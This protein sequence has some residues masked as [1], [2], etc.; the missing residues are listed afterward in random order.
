MKFLVSHYTLFIFAALCVISCNS[1]PSETTQISTEQLNET[2]D[3]GFNQG[4]DSLSLLV[5]QADRSDV[6][7]DP[8]Q[9]DQV[10][11][12]EKS[13]SVK[14]NRNDKDVTENQADSQNISNDDFARAL[15]KSTDLQRRKE[16]PADVPWGNFLDSLKSNTQVFTIDPKKDTVITCKKG[17]R[18]FLPANLLM[19]SDKTGVLNPVQVE[20][21]ECTTLSEFIGEKL[22]TN[23]NDG[24]LETAGMIHIRFLEKGRE[25][26]VRDSAKYAVYFPKKDG[27]SEMNLYYGNVDSNGF[28][29]WELDTLF[30]NRT[31]VK[32]DPSLTTTA[33]GS[34]RNLSP[35]KPYYMFCKLIMTIDGEKMEDTPQ[36]IPNRSYR[37]NNLYQSFEKTLA[38]NRKMRKDFCECKLSS[39]ILVTFDGDGNPYGARFSEHSRHE[40]DSLF[41]DLIRNYPR[42]EVKSDLPG[43]GG[44]ASKVRITYFDKGETNE[45]N[46][47]FNKKYEAF[48]D[49]ALEMV[50]RAELDNYI[51]VANGGGWLNCDLFRRFSGKK[52]NILAKTLVPAATS[53]WLVFRRLYVVIPAQLKANQLWFTQMPLNEPV[54]LIAVNYEN[55]APEMA[56]MELVTK[57]KELF[58]SGFQKFSIEQLRTALD[59]N[60]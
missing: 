58:I 22:T 50:D 25:L 48:Y 28:K 10:N 59:N 43:T 30:D 56:S 8:T 40:Y 1:E 45:Q 3:S 14:T 16:K 23:S 57:E 47:E 11:N 34:N 33:F 27:I 6:F 52:I 13:N 37:T 5:D 36:G 15:L 44:V 24:L 49:Q 7:N 4:E 18:V 17:I 35:A 31:I 38:K 60:F 19:N 55:G 53:V 41:A 46:Y 12:T 39:E 51:L 32:R 2:D 26:F 21:K 20:I 29:T 9:T 54:T 42:N